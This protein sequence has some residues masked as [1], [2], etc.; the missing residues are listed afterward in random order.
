MDRKNISKEF[1]SIFNEISISHSPF[2]LFSDFCFMVAAALKQ[3]VPGQYSQELEQSFLATE[4]KYSQKERERFPRLTN[5]V[6]DALENDCS[7]FL[8]SV[9]MDLGFGN[10]R[11]GQFFTPD[12]VTQMMAEMSLHDAQGIIEKKGFISICD[13]CV[14]AGS[15]LLAAA[16]V[17]KSQGI[18][19]QSKALFYG[20]DIDRTCFHMAFIQL[21]LIGAP[22]VISLGDSLAQTFQDHWKTVGMSN[23]FQWCKGN[24]KPWPPIQTGEAKEAKEKPVL[25]AS[26]DPVFV[27]PSEALTDV[28][29]DRQKLADILTKKNKS[30]FE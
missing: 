27:E 25:I 17:L 21:S 7:D 5:C 3:P 28:Q 6:V 19:F 11:A 22:G 12:H 15:M 9:F 26:K 14:G 1:I 24:F 10:V 16:K 13:P 23:F 8:G 2:T 18:D 29:I 4:K 20:T 30:L